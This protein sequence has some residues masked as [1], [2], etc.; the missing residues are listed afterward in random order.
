MLCP[1]WTIALW[2]RDNEQHPEGAHTHGSRPPANTRARIL[3]IGE[4]HELCYSDPQERASRP[5][6]PWHQR[7]PPDG[8]T[9]SKQYPL[10]TG[11]PT[12]SLALQ[13]HL[14]NSLLR[15]PLSCL[16]H[17]RERPTLPG[18]HTQHHCNVHSKE[19]GLPTTVE[20]ERS[21]T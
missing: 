12:A 15:W 16:G 6:P 2:R 9:E 10:Q 14:I 5:T 8:G 17:M 21:P 19:D 20:G 13:V 11:V 1:T 18:R 4:L 3:S 7:P